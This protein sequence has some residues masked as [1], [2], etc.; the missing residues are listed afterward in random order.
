[1]RT[2]SEVEDFRNPLASFGYVS[3]SSEEPTWVKV[4]SGK[5]DGASPSR[6]EAVVKEHLE[7]DD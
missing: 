2:T 1:M 6:S 7:R 5:D 3:I 4:L